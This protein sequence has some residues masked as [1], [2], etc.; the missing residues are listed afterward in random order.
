ME[1]F[2]EISSNFLLNFQQ[3]LQNNFINFVQFHENIGEE[4]TFLSTT[5]GIFKFGIEN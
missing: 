3:D 2:N 4:G 5:E 1:Q